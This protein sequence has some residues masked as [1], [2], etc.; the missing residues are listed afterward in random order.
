MADDA[1]DKS[2][3]PTPRRRSES[4]QRGQVAKSQELNAAALLLTAMI[5]LALFGQGIWQALLAVMRSSLSGEG[6]PSIDAG[7]VLAALSAKRMGAALAPLMVS[8]LIVG[9]LVL[10]AQVGW[11]FTW[12][13]LIP[14]LD[15]LNPIA[16]FKRIFSGHSLVQLGQ[17]LVKLSL[18]VGIA[19]MSVRSVIHKIV[20]SHTLEFEDIFPFATSLIFELALRLC[21]VLL[22]IAVIDY[23]YQ[24]YRH[25]KQLKMTQEE[26]KEEMKRMEGDPVVQRRRREV[27][28]RL[29][30]QR[31]KSTIPQADVVVTNPTHY[32][33]V[34]KYD[35]DSMIA[36]KVIAKGMDFMALRIREIAAG[37]GVPIVEKP[38]LARGLYADVEIGHEIPERFYRVVAEILAYVYEISGRNLGPAPVPVS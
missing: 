25:E 28:L 7:M 12:E 35:A 14:K 26:V 22:V 4:R 27:Q 19:W 2:E 15:K 20:F 13:P 6:Y 31:M 36:P 8:F 18:I 32:A 17:N 34:I 33:V 1:G 21:L 11:L 29:A 3:A 37:A 5:G 10:L 30:T 23:F 9:V 38:E 16:G 24:R